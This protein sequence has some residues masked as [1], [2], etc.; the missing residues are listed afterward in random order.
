MSAVRC[1]NEK[2]VEGVVE[3]VQEQVVQ[4]SIMFTL[5]RKFRSNNRTS[6]LFFAVRLYLRIQTPRSGAVNKKRATRN[7]V[8]IYLGIKGEKVVV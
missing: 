7:N 6:F 2:W 1:S 5:A 3:K 8:Y 4:F